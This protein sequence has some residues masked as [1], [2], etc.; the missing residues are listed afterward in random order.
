MEKLVFTGVFLA[1]LCMPAFAAEDE[2]ELKKAVKL[3]ELKL[4]VEKLAHWGTRN[5]IYQ[6]DQNG[7]VETLGT[8]TLRTELNKGMVFIRDSMALSWKNKQIKWELEMGCREDSLLRPMHIKSTGEGDD[9][10]KSFS[11]TV[12]DGKAEVAY[13]DG[14]HA[15]IDVPPDT[16]TDFGMF[17]VLTIMPREPGSV[18]A[19]GH[20]LEVSELNL[21]G[22]ATLTCLG[23]QKVTINGDEAELNCIVYERDGDR[24]MEAWVSDNGVLRRIRLDGRKILTE[25]PEAAE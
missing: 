10:F 15:Q 23:K 14:K 13:T 9:E 20:V 25:A 5:Y 6:V 16:L 11:A 21:K 7:K 3:E 22:P 8:V 18:V 19:V 1:C 17:R 12:K 2:V 4:P 24:A